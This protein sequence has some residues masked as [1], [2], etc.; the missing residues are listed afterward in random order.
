VSSVRPRKLP[1]IDPEALRRT[2]QAH[3]AKAALFPART[4]PWPT[5]H[6]HAV[7]AGYPPDSLR[8]LPERAC[9]M[10]SGAAYPMLHEV[11]P[12]ARVVDVGCGGGADALLLSQLGGSRREIVGIDMTEEVVRVARRNGRSAN[13]G[14][15]RFERG[16]AEEL[17]L[18][19]AW[20]DVVIANGVLNLCVVDKILALKETARVLQAGGRL[21]VADRMVREV[22]PD[23]E[24]YQSRNWINGVAGLLPE[25]E[26]V[27]C[28]RAA[29]LTSIETVHRGTPPLAEPG[30]APARGAEFA[31]LVARKTNDAHD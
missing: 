13:A 2:L 27:E 20:A 21:I 1:F 30:E 22:A 10:M 23:L 15:V 12:E 18:P 19:N 3:F 28:V 16:V 7:Q 6:A 5:G 24:R 17:P 4:Q 26:F 25:S 8:S 11:A 14:N 31:V 9:Q 29:G